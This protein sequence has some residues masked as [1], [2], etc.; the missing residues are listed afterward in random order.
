MYQAVLIM[1]ST[2]ESIMGNITAAIMVIVKT[3]IDDK[4][5]THYMC[6][7]FLQ[8]CGNYW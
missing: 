2:M 1:A 3:I 8:K 7:S 5:V 4:G 6:H